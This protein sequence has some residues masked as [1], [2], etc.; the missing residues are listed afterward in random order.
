MLQNLEHRTPVVNPD[1]TPTDYFIRLLQGRGGLLEDAGDQIDLLNAAIAALLARQIIAGVG[2]DGGGTLAADI[3]IDANASAIL[4]TISSTRGVLLYRGA[5]GWAALAPGTAGENLQTNGAGAD[6]TWAVSAGGDIQALLDGISATQGTVLYRNATDWVAL[7][8][9]TAGEFLKTNGAGA[10]PAWAAQAV[11]D[12]Q[13]LLD[14]ISATQGTILY[15]NAADWV[16]LAP[17]TAGDFLKTNGA[18]ANPAWGAPDDVQTL[19]DGISSTQGT[20]LYRDAADWVAL[21]PGTAGYVLQTKGAGQNPAWVLGSGGGS[22]VTP[23]IAVNLTYIPASFGTN[24][25]SGVGMAATVSNTASISYDATN[26]FTRTPQVRTGPTAAN[27]F[28]QVRSTSALF[29]SGAGLKYSGQFGV[30]TAGANMRIN[31]GFHATWGGASDPS[32]A[33]NAFFVGKDSADT[34]LQIMHNDGA[35]TCT[36]IDLGANFPA[37]T[38]QTDHY[39]V[40]LTIDVGGASA[41]YYVHRVNTGDTATGTIA[42]NLPTTNIGMFA[43][44]FG[45]SGATATAC[46]LSFMGFQVQT[47]PT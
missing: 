42:T 5:A 10:N 13:A 40:E 17:G 21:A 22:G 16:A 20:I 6:P 23:D 47:P 12:I 41:S 9:G 26:T 8:P 34:N 29:Q 15:R 27:T 36:K 43:C 18:G 11:A 19:L 24:A 35:G 39:Y 38:S 2:L 7:A 1:G 30:H 33:V 25:V 46:Y 28:G 37:N 44:Q 3:T 32:N 31:C 45:A 4:D 14:G